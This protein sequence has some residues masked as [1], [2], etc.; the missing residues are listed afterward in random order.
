MNKG[1]L[2]RFLLMLIL[3]KNCLF[4]DLFSMPIS[5]ILIASSGYFYKPELD[6]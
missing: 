3:T 2:F 5:E 4:K 1:S 6:F